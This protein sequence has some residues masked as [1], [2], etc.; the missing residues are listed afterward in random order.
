[1]LVTK[2]MGES[3]YL[4]VLYGTGVSNVGSGGGALVLDL[5]FTGSTTLGQNQFLYFGCF[6][7]LMAKFK[8]ML[9]LLCSRLS[10]PR[11]FQIVAMDADVLVYDLVLDL[12]Q[13]Y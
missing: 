11:T 3:L 10:K 1:M 7:D 6:R 2:G 5:T 12:L 13:N 4:S 8:Q 9:P